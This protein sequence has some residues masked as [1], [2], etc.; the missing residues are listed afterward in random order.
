M[1]M[2]AFSGIP[3]KALLENDEKCTELDLCFS[4]CGLPEAVAL[5]CCLKVSFSN[6]RV[7]LYCFVS[8]LF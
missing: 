2:E 6:F 4:G 1:A 7:L 8:G 3:I 5:S